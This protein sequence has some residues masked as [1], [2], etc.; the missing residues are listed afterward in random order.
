MIKVALVDDHQL[1]RKSLSLLV[2]S[3]D[4]IEVEF[5]TNDGLIFLKQLENI[6]ID[7]LLLDLEM[8]I[9]NGYEV[10][11]EAKFIDPNLKVIIVSQITSKEAVHHVMEIGANG[12]LTKNSSPE[13]LEN[14]IKKVMDKD[15]YFDIALSSVL[16]EALLWKKKPTTLS[17]STAVYFTPREIDI[18]K[19]AIKEKSSK[20][21][22]DLLN[23]S[24]RT[25]EKHRTNLMEKTQS[26]NF[27]GV[28]LFAVRAN[29]IDLETLF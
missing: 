2:A 29:V 13:M 16:R 12:Y 23:T 14:A 8:P 21:I 27:I 20:E 9:I 4:G 28:I 6:E 11:K 1:F 3:C 15:Y 22:A 18:V 17:D 10:C 24:I 5:D 25:I 7:V 19:L 26:K